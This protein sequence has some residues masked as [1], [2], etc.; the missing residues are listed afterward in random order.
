MIRLLFLSATFSVALSTGEIYGDLRHG[1]KYVADVSLSLTCDNETVD[2]KTDS[3]GSFRLRVKAAGACK[4]TAKYE[5][6]TPTVS[7]VVFERPTRYR[8]V[9]EE[10][11]GKYILKQG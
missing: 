3:T 8:F 10:K 4:L 1:E 5:G 6:Q 2:T 9:I 11:D 7:V